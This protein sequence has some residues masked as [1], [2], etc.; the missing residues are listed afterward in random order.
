MGLAVLLFAGW[1]GLRTVPRTPTSSSF[2]VPFAQMMLLHHGQAVD[3]ATRLRDRLVALERP[4]SVQTTLKFVTLDIAS[5]QLIQMGTFQAWLELWGQPMV[6][7]GGMDLRAMGMVG[8]ATPEQVRSL[9]TPP[10]PKAE[11]RFLELMIRHHQSGVAM[12][13]SAKKEV[14]APQVR[15]LAGRIKATQG[16]EI[17]QLE[18]LLTERGQPLPTPPTP[19][20]MPGMNH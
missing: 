3:M 11:T 1:L 9:S 19:K 15:V 2:E 13:S 10:L 17:R 7:S 8:I 12:A 4:D 16:T 18:A 5:S 6:Y 14:T 20:D